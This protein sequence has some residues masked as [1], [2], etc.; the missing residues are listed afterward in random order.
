MNAHNQDPAPRGAGFL[1]LMALAFLLIGSF[2]VQTSKVVAQD[3]MPKLGIEPANSDE[4]FFSETVRPGDSKTL[5]VALSNAGKTD[6]TILTY[7]ADVYSLINGGLGV[8]LSDAPVSGA[9]TWL[10]YPT[11]TVKIPHG[12]GLQVEF[13][14]TVPPGVRPGEYV[15]SLVIQNAEPV[16]GTG[17]V[18]VD[19]ILRQAI[20]V[21]IRVPGDEHPGLEIGSVVYRDNALIDSLLI[22]VRNTGN[23]HLKPAGSVRVLD[24]RGETKLDV[25]VGMDSVYAGT[26]TMLE[27]GLTESFDTGDYQISVQL[28]DHD[29]GGSASIVDMPF[30]VVDTAQASAVVRVDEFETVAVRAADDAPIQFVDVSVSIENPGTQIA[31]GQVVLH[32]ER[33]G[34]LVED[35][36]LTSGTPIET[37]PLNVRQRYLPMTGWLPGVYSFSVRIESIDPAT[38]ETAILAASETPVMLEIE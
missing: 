4:I 16:K 12:E 2:W 38:G 7:A 13:Q 17:A 14:L 23:I 31:N 24:P 36:P 15:T 20:A 1:T 3:D 6:V 11:Q 26:T 29:R 5:T 32:V 8:N 10:D 21:A 27:I 30:A 35:Y 33:D 34:E 28:D 22:E 9:T 18:T 25:E 19:Q 37:G